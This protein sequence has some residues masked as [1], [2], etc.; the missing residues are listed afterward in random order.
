MTLIYL[1][2]ERQQ[3]ELSRRAEYF[4]DYVTTLE[5]SYE[6]ISRLKKI[7]EKKENDDN[8]TPPPG[9]VEAYQSNEAKYKEALSALHGANIVMTANIDLYGRIFNTQVP[10]LREA[11]QGM[12]HNME[13][14]NARL[15]R[16]NQ[17]N[18]PRRN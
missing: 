2:T 1:L 7:A 6:K 18:Q 8:I 3:S 16:V 5:N 11:L 9:L 10:L 15:I 14:R 17:A 4:L 13:A 12:M